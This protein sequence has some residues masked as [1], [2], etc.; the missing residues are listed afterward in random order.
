MYKFHDGLYTDV[1]IENT[2]ESNIEVTNERLDNMKENDYSGAFIRIFD[3][4]KWFY[5]SLNDISKI[6]EEIDSLSKLASKDMNINDNPIVKK[7]QSNKEKISFYKDNSVRDISIEKKLS[8][9]SSCFEILKSYD[10]IT[11]WKANYMDLNIHKEFYSSKGSNLSFD[12]QK[13]GFRFG[14]NLS[15]KD[16]KLSEIF[17][18]SD[19]FYSIMSF[20]KDD[21]IKKIDQ[22]IDFIKN[23][24]NIKPGKYTVVLSPLAAG[25]FAHE[26]FG[27]KSEADFMIGDEKMKKEWKLG[28]KVGSSILSI[29]DDGN[30]KGNGFVPFDDEGNRAH[31]TYLI[32]NGIL[33]GRLH[34]STTAADLEEETTGNARALDFEYEPIVRMT[35]TYIEP[36]KLSFEELISDIKEGI[37]IDSISHGSG[38][39]TFTMAPNMSYLIKDG[40][41]AEPVKISVVTGNVFETLN[42]IEN[43]SKEFKLL[44]FS[45]GGC[46]KLEQMPLPVG[47]GGPYV[48]VKELNVQ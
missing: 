33:S 42:L 7:L 8:D 10:L 38:M 18:G 24:K 31:K 45:M 22:S 11:L 20:K 13:V 3:G 39:S 44:S 37:F 47:F 41:I 6:Q 9:L 32:K 4:K 27:H 23:S 34:S 25:I 28:K 2:F 21:L 15:F 43:V 1:R 48:R 17:D 30:E 5:S 26:S 40:K 35:N 36:G 46:G 14:W 19:N 16:E 12:Y 29:V